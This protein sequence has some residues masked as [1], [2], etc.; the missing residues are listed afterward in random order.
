MTGSP[1]EVAA[2]VLLRED[3]AA[4]LQHRDDKPGL[5][6]AGLWTP[7]G[8]H[9]E[10]G[11]SIVA[12][13]RREFEEET[14]YRLGD[15]HLLTAFVDDHVDGAPPLKLTVFWTM[16]DGVQPLECREGQALEFIRREDAPSYPIPGYLIDVWDRAIAAGTRAGRLEGG[17]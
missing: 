15:L 5:S 2:I 17:S 10:A 13:A 14:L 3:G 8:G 9:R 16:Y 6:H 12:C 11:E 7:P 1:D 4:L